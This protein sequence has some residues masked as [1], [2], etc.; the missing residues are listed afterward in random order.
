MGDLKIRGDASNHISDNFTLGH[1]LG[2]TDDM[3]VQ[4]AAARAHPHKFAGMTEEDWRK[5]MKEEQKE[6]GM[7]PSLQG[8]KF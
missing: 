5:Y 7:H 2:I 4:T 1:K 3:G 6:K 8:K